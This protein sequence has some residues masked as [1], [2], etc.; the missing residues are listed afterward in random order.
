[1]EAEEF[2]NLC[3][4]KRGKKF[5]ADEV[6]KMSLTKGWEVVNL[7][8]RDESKQLK[9]S[10]ELTLEGVSKIDPEI[11]QERRV[12]LYYLNQLLGMPDT[13]AKLLLASEDPLAFDKNNSIYE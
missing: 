1:M 8:M 2:N 12:K 10:I 4:T 9:K 3:K 11:L 13:L 5:L 7:V 6:K